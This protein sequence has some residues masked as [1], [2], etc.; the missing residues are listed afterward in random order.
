MTLFEE[1]AQGQLEAY[2]A[3]DLEEFLKW[4]AEDI[5]GIDLD[6]NTVLFTGKAEMRPKYAKR[7]ENEYLTCNL[8]NRMVLHRTVID[9]EEIIWKEN[10]ADSYEAIAI[11]EVAED[12]LITIV[13]FTK[14]KL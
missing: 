12:G 7:F 6:T 13:R 11:Y 9:H 2:N 5:V 8:K 4:Y 3:H 10:K 14:G 1:A